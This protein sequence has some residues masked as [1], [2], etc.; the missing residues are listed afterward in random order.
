MAPGCVRRT[1]SHAYVVCLRSGRGRVLDCGV[2]HS[3]GV[4][5]AGADIGG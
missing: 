1:V 4:G 2:P 5:G 3:L